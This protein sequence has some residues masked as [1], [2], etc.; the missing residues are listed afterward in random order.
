MG[1]IFMEKMRPVCILD[2]LK[3]EDS[4]ETIIPE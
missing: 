1:S 2:S 4:R 3:F